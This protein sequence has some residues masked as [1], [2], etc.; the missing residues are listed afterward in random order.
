MTAY[1]CIEAEV[2]RINYPQGRKIW[3]VATL[4]GREVR[5]QLVLSRVKR[6]AGPWS[7]A[8]SALTFRES[9]SRAPRFRKRAITLP[10][11]LTPFIRT[12]ERRRVQGQAVRSVAA[13]AYHAS[14]YP[15]RSTL[16]RF[17]SE[18]IRTAGQTLGPLPSRLRP[19]RG[20]AGLALGLRVLGL[21]LSSL[22]HHNRHP[23]N[24]ASGDVNVV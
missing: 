23:A 12:I 4:G 22:G 24:Q 3:I 11:P 19:W 8:R 17:R 14:D 9:Q 20:S 2:R 21:A 7:R 6:P 1:R 15:T 10:P 18:N 13:L 5:L 16:A